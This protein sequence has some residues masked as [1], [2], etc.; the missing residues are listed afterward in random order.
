MYNN[1]QFNPTT[2]LQKGSKLYIGTN[3]HTV[4]VYDKSNEQIQQINIPVQNNENIQI[5][6]LAN[7]NNDIWIGTENGIYI[8]NEN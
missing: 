6:T 3:T 4:F 7:I 5:R 2:L 8:L 1:P